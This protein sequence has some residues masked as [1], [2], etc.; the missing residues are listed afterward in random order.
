MIRV[1][2]DPNPGQLVSRAMWRVS[3][4]LRRYVPRDVCVVDASQEAD[5]HVLHV[6]GSYPKTAIRSREYAV[7]QYCWKTAGE[8]DWPAFWNA[9]RLTWSYYS[10][11]L[12]QRFYHAPL[13]VDGGVFRPNSSVRDVDVVTSGYVAGRG[14]EAIEEVAEAAR[15]CRRQVLHVGPRDIQGM[16]S[17]SEDTWRNAQDITDEELARLYGSAWWVSGLRYVE[18]FE[19]PAI[20]GAACGARPIVFDREDMRQ[21]Y[22]GLAEFVPELE[23]SHEVVDALIDVLSGSPRHVTATEREALLKRFSWEII[24]EGFWSRLLG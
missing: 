17:R 8:H 4:A 20:E 22:D 13:G 23:D 10:L 12:D 15:W 2:L 21:W 9:A 6:I 3:K 1:F 16:S 7:I 5:L 19:L 11:P 18:G 24:A 14:A